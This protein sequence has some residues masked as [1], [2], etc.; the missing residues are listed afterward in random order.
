VL[1]RN[2]DTPKIGLGGVWGIHDAYEARQECENA[3]AAAFAELP[4]RWV[5]PE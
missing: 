4:G 1:W 2:I 3:G 5:M